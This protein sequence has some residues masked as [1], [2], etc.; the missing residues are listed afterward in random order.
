MKK[1]L[2]LLLLFGFSAVGADK[3]IK[4]L[5]GIQE[6]NFAKPSSTG[7]EGIAK[8]GI[9]IYV[10]DYSDKDK[11]FDKEAIENQVKLRLIQAGVKVN[12]KT[13]FL[14]R[15]SDTHLYINAFPYAN[16]TMFNMQVMRWVIIPA[17][18]KTYRKRCSVWSLGSGFGK[19]RLR[20]SIN[21]D[22]DKFLL[23]YL[24]ANPKKKED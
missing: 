13:T 16:Y 11:D 8:N 20:E 1:L 10:E 19:N 4:P 21:E 7:L 6:L 9:K 15:S 12:A 24:K 22:M 23:D 14:A 17:N 3:P 18:G 2:L 5:T